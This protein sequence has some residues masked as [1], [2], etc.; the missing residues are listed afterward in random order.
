MPFHNLLVKPLRRFAVRE[1]FNRQT[2]CAN[3][4]VEVERIHVTHEVR[5]AVQ[6]RPGVDVDDINDEAFR[7]G[8][9][10]VGVE[11][12]NVAFDDPAIERAAQRW[13]VL[14]TA[15]LVFVLLGCGF[16][17]VNGLYHRRGNEADKDDGEDQHQDD[18]ENDGALVTPWI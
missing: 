1:L 16:E 13:G 3:R 6:R 8:R 14:P 17:F 11:R 18:D 5:H 9:C 12:A 15:I 4:L 7:C 2:V 10:G